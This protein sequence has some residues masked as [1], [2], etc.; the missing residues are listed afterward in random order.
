L[1]LLRLWHV[2]RCQL[3]NGLTTDALACGA[4]S[5]NHLSFRKRRM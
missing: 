4:V 3:T 1:W 2:P 5:A